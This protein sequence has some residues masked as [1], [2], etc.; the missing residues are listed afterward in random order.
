MNKQKL[1]HFFQEQRK[2]KS[3]TQ[4]YLR[5]DRMCA[6]S[7]TEFSQ[8]DWLS[9]ITIEMSTTNYVNKANNNY[10]KKNFKLKQQP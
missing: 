9:F 3:S 2:S 5:V 4:A 1:C 6:E 8:T 10:M 7:H